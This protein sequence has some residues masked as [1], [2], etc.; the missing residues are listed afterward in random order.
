M[1]DSIN[2]EETSEEGRVTQ[3]VIDVTPDNNSQFS[4]QIDQL[5]SLSA[6]HSVVGSSGAETLIGTS[7][8]DIIFSGGLSEGIETIISNGGSDRL[9]IDR[10]DS[11]A[12]NNANDLAGHFRVQDF[13]IADVAT[14]QEADV[15][16]IGNF[17]IGENLNASNIG[18]YLHV[19]SGTYTSNQ[20]G[21]FVDREGTLTDDKRFAL[22]TDYYS[23]GHGT[24]FFIEFQRRATDTNFEDI[25]GFQDNTEEQ[26]QAL[27]DLGFLDISGSQDIS[28][29]YGT[30]EG[31]ELEGTSGS[32][33]IYSRGTSD[34][35]ESVRSNGGSDRLILENADSFAQND[36]S[37]VRAHIRIRDFVIDNVDENQEADII[38]LGSILMGFNIGADELSKYLHVVSGAHGDERTLVFVDRDGHFTDA[39]RLALSNELEAGGHGADVVLEFQGKAGT[40]NFQDITGEADN[41]EEQFQALID[42][43]FLDVSRADG[44]FIAEHDVD[45]GRTPIYGTILPDQIEGTSANESI[46]SGGVYSNAES[47]RGNGGSDKL[48]IREE[49]FSFASYTPPIYIRGNNEADASN[50]NKHI[51][52]R[53][54]TIA[55]VNLNAE[56]DVLDLSDLFANVELNESNINDYLHI[57][58]NPWGHPAISSLYINKDGD[59]T[60]EGRAAIDA[61]PLANHGVGTDLLIEFQNFAAN[62]NFETITGYADNTYE[63]FKALMDLGFLVLSG[64]LP[65]EENYIYGST[66][67]D[68]ILGSEF[69]DIIVPGDITTNRVEHV[70]GNGGSDKLVFSSEHKVADD[71]ANDANG[72]FRIR[73]FTIG[74]TA[75]NSEADVLSLKD[76]LN[77][78]GLGAEDLVNYVHVM[79]GVYGLQRSGIFVDREGGFTDAD[80]AAFEASP[81]AGGHGADLFLEFQGQVANNNL[82]DITGYADNSVEQ[83]QSLIDMGF[84][85]VA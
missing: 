58:S 68:Y 61:S 81:Q 30:S 33:W 52:L 2:P 71:N 26:F 59:F 32:E 19:V 53:D 4:Y 7:A 18:N 34:S 73:D 39:K 85:E 69:D 41:T 13:T 48:I 50:G 51:R 5:Q 11:H 6:S 12:R 74:N 1:N 31:D 46:Y 55:D 15:F 57:V 47:I 35:S 76:L 54:F 79:S 8:D 65:P 45:D 66:N 22:S 75:T 3:T 64:P 67:S 60:D 80:R 82:E 49:D 37:D 27:I 21:I 14:N 25:T 16:D 36:A 77:V 70:N 43:G 56:A 40:N 17:L 9:L 72:H 84:L 78:E 63:Q 23:G 10:D 42:L 28:R 38:D 44:K 29:I 24:E 20:S 62:S 83:L